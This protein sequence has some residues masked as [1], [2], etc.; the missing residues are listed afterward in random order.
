MTP[1][2]FGFG[3][4]FGYGSGFGFGF[5]CGF[6]PDPGPWIRGH[7]SRSGAM[8]PDP[9]PWIRVRETNSGNKKNLG[10]V[11]GPIAKNERGHRRGPRGHGREDGNRRATV[12]DP[13][14]NP[15]GPH[16][17]STVWGI[18]RNRIYERQKIMKNRIC[19]KPK[20]M[21]NRTRAERVAPPSRNLVLER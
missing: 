12:T 6:G 4:G 1:A 13:Y 8:D 16:S 21:N 18:M 19:E 5:G 17:A 7:G 2:F 10:A 15:R 14:Q 11:S 3:F 20:I 9:G